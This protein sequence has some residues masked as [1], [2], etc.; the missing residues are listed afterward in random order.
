MNPNL[1]IARQPILC[2]DESIFAFELLYR[3]SN[4]SSKIQDDREATVAVLSNVLNKF[5][6]KN[7]L[8]DKKAFIKADKN[9]LMHE[10]V[11]YIPKE[12]FIFSL[13]ASM[14][15]TDALKERIIELSELG[16]TLAINDVLLTKEVLKSFN[17]LL[18]YITYIKVD[19]N[20]TEQNLELLKEIA[21]QVIFTKVETHELYDKAKKHHAKLVQGF[22][23]SKPKV[24]EQEKFDP[25][26]LRAVELCNF[27]MSDA[28]I[29]E[30]VLKFE[31][32]HAISL[33]L[34]KYVNSGLFHFRHTIS[35]IRQVLTLMG[36]T[37][38][39]QWLMLMMYSTKTNQ[40]EQESET[41]LMQLLKSRTDLM[42]ET[43]KQLKDTN[44]QN[45]T[46]KVY[47]L[48]VLS[49]LD[50]LF[51]AN[52]RRV[53]DELNIDI[54]IKDAIIDGKGVLGEILLFAKSLE[55]FDIK[56]VEN[57]CQKYRIN[58]QVLED[59]SL[60]VIRSANEFELSRREN[61]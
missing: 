14:N 24:L 49:L 8:G 58:T 46:S 39:T 30:I 40:S 3:D 5:G 16:Y 60:E 59:L 45:L 44:V 42:V 31:Q 37:P 10:V 1:Y 48:G 25:Q 2:S 36:R 6:V 34:L 4:K 20:S 33:Q 28:S 61:S 29:D 56:E 50:A 32:N 53:L 27:M 15:L 52:I 26:S 19:I 38:L 12:Y 43:S 54:E 21:T 11:F 47:F 55:N 13:Q 9:F 23:F 57:F 22:F 41:A 18:E 17:S 35:S 7:L 51:N